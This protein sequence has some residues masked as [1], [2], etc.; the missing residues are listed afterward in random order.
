MIEFIFI[1]G[2]MLLV[3]LFIAWASAAA[4]VSS[5]RCL[6]VLAGTFLFLRSP[7]LRAWHIEPRT[8]RRFL[9]PLTER[10]F[11]ALIGVVLCFSSAFGFLEVGVV[12]VRQRSAAASAGRGSAR[13]H[14][15][16][17]DALGGIAYGSRGWHYPLARQFVVA[18]TV[19]G[20]GLGMLALGWRSRGYLRDGRP[21]PGLRWR[22]R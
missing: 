10:G 17:E 8:S 9:G 6:P 18:L 11:P 15:R 12:R 4:A 22:P 21:W 5:R 19:M 3:A 16:R 14:Q 2:P 20:A 7:A 1:A 13:H